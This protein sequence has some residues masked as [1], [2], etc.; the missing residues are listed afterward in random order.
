MSESNPSR[1]KT[2]RAT[3]APAIGATPRE[4]RYADRPP[5]VVVRPNGSTF[6]PA[7]LGLPGTYGVWRQFYRHSRGRRR[8]E[9]LL[10]FAAD[11]RLGVSEAE[12]VRRHPGVLHRI[13]KDGSFVLT[14]PGRRSSDPLSPRPQ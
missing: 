6:R 11:F 4:V 3:S 5:E 14:I 8:R 12:R 10:G 2:S 13:G 1:M 7:Y 9:A